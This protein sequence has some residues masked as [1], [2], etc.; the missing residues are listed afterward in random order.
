MNSFT[1]LAFSIKK[2]QSTNLLKA[3]GLTGAAATGLGLG[4]VLHNSMLGTEAL[5]QAAA[6]NKARRQYAGLVEHMD[7]INNMKSEASE[8]AAE[9][10]KLKSLVPGTQL[11]SDVSTLKAPEVSFDMFDEL[12]RPLSGNNVE[13]PIVFG[14]RDTPVPI[15]SFSGDGE[16]QILGQTPARVS[17]RYSLIDKMVSQ[18]RESDEFLKQLQNAKVI[19]KAV[20]PQAKI[21]LT[22]DAVAKLQAKLKSIPENDWDAR[23]A[24]MDSD[25]AKFE[26]EKQKSIVFDKLRRN[27]QGNAKKIDPYEA[28]KVSP[29]TQNKIL[30]VFKSFSEPIGGTK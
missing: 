28:I 16:Y 6:L 12:P 30:K 1:K 10:R 3:L 29:E 14:K 22:D 11:L 7:A 27:M 2:K 5:E 15:F 13:G 4:H 8:Q 17:D 26:F 23:K 20:E 24:R 25:A 19:P 18:S 9:I 21:P